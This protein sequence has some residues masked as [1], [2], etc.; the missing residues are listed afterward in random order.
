M[1]L[2]ISPEQSRLTFTIAPVSGQ[3]TQRAMIFSPLTA[4]RTYTVQYKVSLTDPAWQ[5]L[6][7]ATQSDNGA[8]RTVTDTTAAAAKFYRVQVSKP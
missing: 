2:S 4:G 5:T 7:G 1:G 6:T 3:P 8:I